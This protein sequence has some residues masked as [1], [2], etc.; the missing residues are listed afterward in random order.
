[1]TLLNL[2][3]KLHCSN[4]EFELNKGKYSFLKYSK[5]ESIKIE[6]IVR[7]VELLFMVD[8]L[9][10][11]KSPEGVY[12]MFGTK[13]TY[14][15]FSKPIVDYID[16]FYYNQKSVKPIIH[17]YDEKTVNLSLNHGI[18]ERKYQSLFLN[19]SKFENKAYELLLDKLCSLEE[20]MLSDLLV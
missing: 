7:K 11:R 4:I 9:Y 20:S 14:S 13:I 3:E 10:Y 17:T 5:D 1:M 8:E 2:N 18:V 6:V 12:L 15:V 16:Y 19:N